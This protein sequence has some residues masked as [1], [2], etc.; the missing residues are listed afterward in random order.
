M[1][2]GESRVTPRVITALVRVVH[3]RKCAADQDHNHDKDG[4]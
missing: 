4:Q 1:P 2:R 3:H